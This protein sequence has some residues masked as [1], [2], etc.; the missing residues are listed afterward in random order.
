MHYMRIGMSIFPTSTWALALCAV[1]SVSARADDLPPLNA[2]ATM[3]Q[4]GGK[5]IW[6]DLF[7]ADQAAAS[8]FYAAL[9]GWEAKTLTRS[10]PAGETHTYIVLSNEGRP[11]AGIARR[12]PAMKDAVHGRWVG[13]VSVPDVPKALAA[14]TA[15]G[16]RVLFPAKFLP[17]RGTQA[18]FIDP[19]G[20]EFGIMHSTSGD[21]AEYAPDPGDWAW[22]ELFARDPAKA[23]KFYRSVA[24]YEVLPDTRAGRADSFVLVSGGYSRASVLPLPDRAKANPVCL[25]FVRVASVKD[26]VA[27]VA[28]L[29]GRV[30]LAPGD[31][32]A[33]YWKAIIAD[34]T[35]AAVGVVQLTEPP[36][37]KER[38]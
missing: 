24:G 5:F 7:T 14:A 23:G 4:F 18:V 32:P 22:S 9:F 8:G 33:Q 1:L 13:Y 16:S 11:V 27:R 26:T 17:Q 34:P 10:S 3:D 29:G 35:G 2:P 20:V 31:E 28:A 36:A 37:A 6:A 19:D 12:P 25:L 38:P 30:L 15:G 21:P